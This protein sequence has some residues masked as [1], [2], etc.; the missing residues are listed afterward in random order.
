M[1]T[2]EALIIF[3]PQT[4]GE[5]LQGDKG[6]FEEAIKKHEGKILN[7]I[8]VGKRSL[9][10]SIKKSKEGYCVAFLFELL[11]AKMD[12]FKR[13]LQLAEEILKFTLVQKSKADLIRQAKP[14]PVQTAQTAERR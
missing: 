9:G 12:A 5:I 1:R 14:A 6:V 2:Y 11:P 13:S 4:T 3:H 10:Y 8:E 7:R